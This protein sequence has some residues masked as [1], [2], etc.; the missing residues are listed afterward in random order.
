MSF[1]AAERAQ[2]AALAQLAFAECD[3]KGAGTA[4]QEAFAEV[5]DVVFEMPAAAVDAAFVAA[6]VTNGQLSPQGF[7]KWLC[8]QFGAADSGQIDA[9]VRILTE[10]CDLEVEEVWQVME[11]AAT[12]VRGGGGENSSSFGC[13]DEAAICSQCCSAEANS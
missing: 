11:E 13:H 8:N 5:C 1:A 2:R 10:G 9:L 6:G 12:E 3:R 7:D 4:S